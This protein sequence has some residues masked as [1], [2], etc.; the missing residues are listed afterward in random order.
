MEHIPMVDLKAQYLQIQAALQPCILQCAEEGKYIQGRSVAAFENALASYTGM[1]QV[2][3]C[4]NGTDAL[5]LAVMALNL[6]KGSKI[7]V[8]AFTFIAPVEVISFL[9]YEPIYADIDP[10][11]FNI[12]LE[13]IHAVYTSEVSA[14][15]VVHLFGLPCKDIDRIY[16]FCNEKNIALIEDNAQSLGA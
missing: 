3:S 13:H 2:I 11:A 10:T 14:I 15:I 12:T 4:G 5:Q 9:G 8:P 6:P 16:A 7:I 1:S